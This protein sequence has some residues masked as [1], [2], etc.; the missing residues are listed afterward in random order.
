MHGAAGKRLRLECRSG[1]RI[2]FVRRLRPFELEACDTLWDPPLAVGAVPGTTPAWVVHL[3]ERTAAANLI[4]WWW[5]C[6]VRRPFSRPADTRRFRDF[7]DPSGTDASPPYREGWHLDITA[8]MAQQGPFMGSNCPDWPARREGKCHKFIGHH[9]PLFRSGHIVDPV[10]F[11]Q[12][13]W[14]RRGRPLAGRVFPAFSRSHLAKL[15]TRL[16]AVAQLPTRVFCPYALRRGWQNALQQAGAPPA[17]V[18]DFAG[19][20]PP[21]GP[22]AVSATHK[23]YIDPAAEA[24]RPFWAK[25]AQLTLQP[26]AMRVAAT[27]TLRR[28]G[29]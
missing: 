7:D 25:A 27:A 28:T 23:S 26:M 1:V 3:A 20:A 24:L 5:R 29:P 2:A 19:H 13:L 21:P 10:R 4:A 11:L 15:S 6:R 16:A 12:R 14:L 22:G 18:A 9:L 17:L 8:E